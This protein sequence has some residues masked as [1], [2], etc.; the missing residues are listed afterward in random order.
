MGVHTLEAPPFLSVSPRARYVYV[1][2]QTFVK[3]L[4]YLR[5][6]S[7]QREKRNENNYLSG[8]R[9][10]KLLLHDARSEKNKKN[11]YQRELRVFPFSR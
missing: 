7:A 11:S 2:E 10:A 5:V 9:A 8:V 1:Q 3:T 6:T 4:A